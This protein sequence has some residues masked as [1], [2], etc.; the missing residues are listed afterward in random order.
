MLQAFINSGLS[1]DVVLIPPTKFFRVEFPIRREI[2]DPFRQERRV[3]EITRSVFLGNDIPPK[4]LVEEPY[5]YYEA[6]MNAYYAVT[7]TDADFP[8][9]FYPSR[10]EYRHWV[11]SDLWRDIEHS[12]SHLSA[13]EQQVISIY[14]N[15]MIVM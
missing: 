4:Q 9:Q 5:V 15:V 2:F 10:R 3:A 1:P 11:V 13:S 6:D 12:P 14:S 7:F 8:S